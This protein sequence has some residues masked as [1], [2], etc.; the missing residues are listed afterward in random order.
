MKHYQIRITGKVQNVGFRFKAMEMAYKCG[1][2]G[3]VKNES[4][5]VV[6][7]EAEGEEPNMERFLEWCRVGPLGA[8][9]LKAETTEGPIKNYTSFDIKRTESPEE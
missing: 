2:M 3:F 7:I 8:R 6:F 1:V 4:G 9:V 5:S